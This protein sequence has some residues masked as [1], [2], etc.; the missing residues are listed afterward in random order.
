ML[1]NYSAF[2]HPGIRL[3]GCF[4]CENLHSENCLTSIITVT[5]VLIGEIKCL[6]VLHTNIHSDEENSVVNQVEMQICTRRYK[7]FINQATK[8]VQYQILPEN[9]IATRRLHLITVHD[10]LCSRLSSKHITF[11]FSEIS[12]ACVF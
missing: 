4:E 2:V 7:Y 3:L 5:T 8:T 11:A 12:R 9:S 1:L 6:R 10:K